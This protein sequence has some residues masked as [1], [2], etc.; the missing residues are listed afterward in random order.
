MLKFSSTNTKILLAA[1]ELNL[2]NLTP[3]LQCTSINRCALFITSKRKKY[4]FIKFLSSLL[5]KKYF[6]PFSFFSLSL[7]LRLLFFLPLFL[8]IF[9]SLPHLLSASSSPIFII[10]DLHH[11]RSSSSSPSCRPMPLTHLAFIELKRTTDPSKLY[12]RSRRQ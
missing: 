8:L 11:R 1:V 9:F 6:F 12:A 7:S 2:K 5:L 10:L 4:Y 3:L